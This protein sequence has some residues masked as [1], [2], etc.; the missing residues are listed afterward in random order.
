MKP[1][2][3]NGLNDSNQRILDREKCTILCFGSSN[4]YHENRLEN[5]RHG[6]NVNEKSEVWAANFT[7]PWGDVATQRQ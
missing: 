5:A 3:P 6:N 2:L 7:S 4:L 1:D